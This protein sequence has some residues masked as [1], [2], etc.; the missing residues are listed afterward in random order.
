MLYPLSYGGE[1]DNPSRAPTV[2]FRCRMHE[3]PPPSPARTRNSPI[4]NNVWGLFRK[5]NTSDDTPSSA[6]AEVADA[7][8]TQ[9]IDLEDE[10][11][12]DL[13]EG[14]GVGEHPGAWVDQALASRG[15]RPV[16]IDLDPAEGESPDAGDRVDAPAASDEPDGAEHAPLTTRTHDDLAEFEAEPPS[17]GDVDHDAP[18]H[19]ETG[20]PTTAGL[21]A[22]AP[23]R[24]EEVRRRWLEELATIGG[25]SSLRHFRADRGTYVDLTTAHPSG[26][27]TLLAGRP[28]MLTSLLRE[29]LAFRTALDAAD[30][31]ALKGAELEASRALS[32]VQLAIGL[33]SWTTSGG[34]VRC[35]V[36]LRSATLRRLGRDYEVRLRGRLQPNAA[37]LHS[38]HNDGVTVRASALLAEAGD[39]DTLVPEPAFELLRSV[40]GELPGFAVDARAALSTFGDVAGAMLADSADL[41]HPVLDALT[42]HAG[43]RAGLTTTIEPE[44][45]TNPDRRDPSTDRLLLDADT[46]QE[47]VI[48]AILGGSNLVVETLPGTGLTQTVVNAIGQLVDRDRRVLVV[49]PR[50]AS[51]RAIRS[52]L[53][54]AGLDGLAMT[55]RTVR[56]DAIAA[57]SRNER[58]QRPATAELD[59]ALVRLRHVLADYRTALTTKSSRF[60]VSPFQVLEQL[61][62]LELLEVPP[63]TTARLDGQTLER[64]ADPASRAATAERLRELS[65]LGAFRFG[66]DDSPWY[67]VMFSTTEEVGRIHRLAKELTDGRVEEVIASGRGIVAQT[68]LR[69][70]ESFGQL[71]V[72][73]RLLADIRETLDR[74]HPEVFDADLPALIE[75]TGSRREGS[76]MSASRRRELRAIARD[77]VRPGAVVSDL[78]ETLKF[79]HR[80]RILWHR[81]VNDGA[82]PNVPVGIEAAR[83]DYRAVAGEIQQID[84]FLQDADATTLVDTPIDE[85]PQRLRELAD[86][87]EYLH[88]VVERL[89]ITEELREQGLSPLL[90]DL[91]E[92]RLEGDRVGD[93]LEQA[94]WQSVLERQLQDEKGLLNANTRILTRLENDFRVVDEAHT[95]SSAEQLMWQFAQA[96]KVGLIDHADEAEALRTLLRAPG[97]G[98]RSL[99]ERAPKLSRSI[100]QVW[101]STPYDVPRIDDRIEFDTVLIVDAGDM[102]TAEAIGAI[103][104]GRQV[105]AFGDP[106]TQAPSPF[107]IAVRPRTDS[108]LPRGV[109]ADVVRE[110]AADSIYAQLVGFLPVMSLTR[111]YRAGGEDLVELV[112]HRFYGGRLEA[113]PWAGAFLGHS[114]LTYSYVSGGTGMPDSRTGNVE[115]TDAEVQRVVELVIDHAIHRP[116]ES[117]MVITA[118]AVHAQRVEQAVWS[119]L[120]LRNEVV[121]FFTG[122]RKE[123]FL[124]MTIEQASALARDRVIFSLGYGITPHGRVLSEFGVLATPMG[125]R[126]LA[127]AMTR[128][129]RSLVIVSCVRPD[130][131]DLSKMTSGTIGLAEILTELEERTERPGGIDPFDE[132]KAPMLVD[133]A[134]R[135]SVLGMRV[136]LDYRGR[137]PLVASYGPRAIAIDLDA[138][139]AEDA[140]TLR[141]QLRLRPEL[142]KRLGWYY[143]R[144]HAFELFA[145]PESVARRIAV[146]LEVPLPDA[147]SDAAGTLPPAASRSELAAG[148][149]AEREG[150]VL[151]AGPS[152]SAEATMDVSEASATMEHSAAQDRDDEV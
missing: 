78:H 145:N 90:D 102:S 45:P 57:I 132:S 18:R 77:L 54:G 50:A 120:S 115:A 83:A 24:R 7:H 61:S 121:D 131:L 80:Q 142:L 101:V 117:L 122:P 123:P 51:I 100:A 42:G 59:D 105:V 110:R 37:L 89:A 86:D 46:E 69:P 31:V 6:S 138:V 148:A 16:D 21:L 76:E 125:E 4:L 68:N 62:A 55:P 114:S 12:R 44:T 10:A 136:D 140:P 5:R 35:P 11:E 107:S 63:T 79:V 103:R 33:A 60:G 3:T 25:P 129:R 71:G 116:R 111:S 28:V 119:A 40:A 65:R 124:V 26:V 48:D 106:V 53:R 2:D 88:A 27:A 130:Q 99:V 93:E 17:N 96:W 43:A 23:D 150:R 108:A 91:L 94:W 66:P 112:N 152:A 95:S 98:A 126:A 49:T 58:A 146:A 38:L 82:L 109:D 47:R 64:L 149:N 29:P 32:A 137:I 41:A 39:G 97:V 118:S 143:L 15:M 36:F 9:E 56:R 85:L 1:R 30:L 134:R 135:L 147:A 104:R 22:G 141:E 13:G 70:P 128:A 81:Y 67:G 74:F 8:E 133:L 20:A 34:D 72:V 14:V 52:R 113:M 127:V 92:R 151:E 144:V 19:E 75:A 139:D 73:L 87:S 84:E